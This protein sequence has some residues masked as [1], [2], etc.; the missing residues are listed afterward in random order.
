MANAERKHVLFVEDEE[1]IRGVAVQHF[2]RFADQFRVTIVENGKVALEI[3]ERETV[4]LVVTD[5]YMPVMDGFELIGI[6]TEKYPLMPIFVASVE[7]TPEL[8]ASLGSLPSLR[9]FKKPYDFKYLS[10]CILA[11]LKARAQGEIS[12]IGV[13]SLFQLMEM[14]Q[15]T[16]R[17][18]I[19]SAD[20]TGEVIFSDGQLIDAKTGTLVAEAAAYEIISWEN[21]T[22]GIKSISSLPA[23][24]ITHPLMTILLE[25]MRLKDEKK[26]NPQSDAPENRPLQREKG[27][28]GQGANE[29]YDGLKAQKASIPAELISLVK[30][31]P[32]IHACKIYNRDDFVLAKSSKHGSDLTIALSGYFEPVSILESAMASG[33]FTYFLVNVRDGGRFLF[34][35]FKQLRLI[36]SLKPEFNITEFWQRINK[37]RSR[38][39]K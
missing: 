34:F 30:T 6:L 2:E 16:C 27:T 12:G 33:K 8:D 9:L 35:E 13:P 38:M 23:K 21:A 11:D 15:R 32:G 7:V 19:E 5:L 18:T 24:R 4:D 37:V 3:A 28:E 17:L 36:L 25:G 22:V 20:K 26:N 10:E 14:E 29:E 1:A 39:K 31:T